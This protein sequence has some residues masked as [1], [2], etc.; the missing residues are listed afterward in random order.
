MILRVIKT[1]WSGLK[2]GNT[3][4]VSKT[5]WP[6][7]KEAP[8]NGKDHKLFNTYQEFRIRGYPYMAADGRGL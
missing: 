6:E 8:H 2:R 3:R 5:D 4:R 1:K 7:Y